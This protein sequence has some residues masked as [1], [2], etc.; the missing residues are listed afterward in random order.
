M[1]YDKMQNK[2]IKIT[3]GGLSYNVVTKNQR[4]SESDYC[5]FAS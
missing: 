5:F 2:K 4:R 3:I 1:E